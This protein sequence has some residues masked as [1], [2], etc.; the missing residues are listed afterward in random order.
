MPVQISK[1]AGVNQNDC[2]IVAVTEPEEKT[3]NK[4]ILVHP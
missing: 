1:R 4:A 2:S 3:P